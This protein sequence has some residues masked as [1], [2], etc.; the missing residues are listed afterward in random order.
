MCKVERFGFPIEVS[1]SKTTEKFDD[2]I[3]VDIGWLTGFDFERS[4]CMSKIRA[5]VAH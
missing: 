5:M 3:V 4:L 2:M 1:T